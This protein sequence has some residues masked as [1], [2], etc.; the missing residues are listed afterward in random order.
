MENVKIYENAMNSVNGI[1]QRIDSEIRKN[2][3]KRE[4]VVEL[5]HS[6]ENTR[7]GELHFIPIAEIIFQFFAAKGAISDFYLCHFYDS[8]QISESSSEH[9]Y[10]YTSLRV[11]MRW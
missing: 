9:E 11:S 2:I 4:T 5:K 8:K 10:D 1:L 6:G 3:N 7:E